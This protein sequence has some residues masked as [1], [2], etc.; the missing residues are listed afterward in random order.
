MEELNAKA[1]ELQREY[2]KKWRAQNKD[3]VKEINKRYWL[4]K[5]KSEAERGE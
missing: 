2:F 3:R 1:K 4:K 5:A